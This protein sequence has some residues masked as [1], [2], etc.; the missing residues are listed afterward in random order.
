[1]GWMWNMKERENLG[2]PQRFLTSK[3]ENLELSFNEKGKQS[4]AII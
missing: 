1:M 2:M 3:M 4:G